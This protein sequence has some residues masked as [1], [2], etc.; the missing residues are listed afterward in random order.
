MF[1]SPQ[2]FLNVKFQ[3]W[4]YYELNFDVNVWNCGS[5]PN[6]KDL[7]D[8]AAVPR[9]VPWSTRADAPLFVITVWLSMLGSSQGPAGWPLIHSFTGNV[10]DL[11]QLELAPFCFNAPAPFWRNRH[12]SCLNKQYF[13]APLMHNRPNVCYSC[14]NCGQLRSLSPHK[15]NTIILKR[16]W[17]LVIEFSKGSRVLR[18]G[19]GQLLSCKESTKKEEGWRGEEG[20]IRSVGSIYSWHTLFV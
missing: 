4:L 17:S 19:G 2:F 5:M 12:N 1:F 11:S 9:A 8:G 13:V 14:F 20:V 10:C 18:D 15:D 3:V 6:K 16:L 7:R